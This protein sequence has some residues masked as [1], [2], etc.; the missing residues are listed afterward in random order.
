M[1]KVRRLSKILKKFPRRVGDD[2]S[3]APGPYRDRALMAG[4]SA[5]RPEEQDHLTLGATGHQVGEIFYNILASEE[6]LRGKLRNE[7]IFNKRTK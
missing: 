7:A 5:D 1:R 6:T 3:R 4:R 2:P